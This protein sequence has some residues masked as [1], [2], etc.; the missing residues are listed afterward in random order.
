MLR[1]RI[2]FAS[3]WARYEQVD[4]AGADVVLADM[5][6]LTDMVGL[7]YQRWQHAL[8]ATGRLLLA[9]HA[10]QADAA[11]NHALD[12]GTA[13]AA[14][15]ALGTFG[16]LLYVIRQHQGRLDEIVDFFV[17][18]ARDNPSIAVLRAAIPEMLCELGRIDE[19]HDLLVAEAVDDFDFPYNDSWLAA[20]VDLGNVAATTGDQAVARALVD[21]LTPFADHV[22]APSAVLVQ[23]AVARPLARMATV[24]G[25]YVRAEQWFAIAH[26][27][28][29]RLRAPF[30]SAL[31]QLDHADLCITRDADDDIERA[32]DLATTAADTATKFGCSA[33]TKRAAALLAAI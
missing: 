7:P 3:L 20:M 33:L 6:A 25:D 5:E 1:A 14:P 17:D 13:A 32:R 18:A 31:G 24:L 9:G 23:G 10:D 21:R 4:I 26:D 11:N 15:E 30:W 2:R 8:L 28:H 19:A 16:G 29:H 22:V 27:I 12:L